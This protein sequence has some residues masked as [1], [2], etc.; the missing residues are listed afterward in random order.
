MIR[1]TCVRCRRNLG[2]RPNVYSAIQLRESSGDPGGPPGVLAQGPDGNLYGTSSFSGSAPVDAFK[3]TPSGNQTV[4]RDLSASGNPPGGVTLGTN[5]RFY[6]VIP[7]SD[8]AHQGAVFK[9][10]SGGNLTTIYSFTGGAD[11]S[12]PLAPPIEGIDGTFYG[13]A[14]LGGNL[15]LCGIGC[16][17]VYEITPSGTHATLHGF[18][19]A[20]GASPH[21]PLMQ[22]VNGNLYGTTYEGGSNNKG[23]L[24]EVSPSGKFSVLFDFHGTDGR[25][26]TGGLI[27]ASDGDLYG[28]TVLG[29][30]SNDGVVFKISHGTY[31]VLHS[32]TG[33]ADGIGPVGGLLQATDGILGETAA[34][35][36]CA[37]E[38]SRFKHP[39]RLAREPQGL[40]FA[41]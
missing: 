21:D 29:G 9:L 18:N 26:P 22:A 4:L 38:T 8:T 23:T 37:L 36:F 1:Y 32:F 31:T 13:T 28:V 17:V 3:F 7:N 24:F 25:G 27:Q 30:A 12:I 34:F 33:G 2:Q 10:T 39:N 15:D 19:G 40:A 20:D 11:G 5:G 35:P 14:A 6:G 16:G 41:P